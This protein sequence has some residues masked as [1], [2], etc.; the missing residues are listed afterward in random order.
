MKTNVY[1][2]H[3]NDETY[4]LIYLLFV[5]HFQWKDKVSTTVGENYKR[6]LA[7]K[8]SYHYSPQLI[9]IWLNR[10]LQLYEVF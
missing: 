1:L 3:K 4:N 9:I 10:L 8:K 7:I 6:I 5:T 2:K